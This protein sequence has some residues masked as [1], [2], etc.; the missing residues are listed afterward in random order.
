MMFGQADV[1][2]LI[3]KLAVQQRD[4]T[5]IFSW[6]AGLGAQRLQARS[7]EELKA[8]LL[9]RLGGTNAPQDCTRH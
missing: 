2:M 7:I 1:D 8:I 4:G 6:P 9:E 3:P 5:W